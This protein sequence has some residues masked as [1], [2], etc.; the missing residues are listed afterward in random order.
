MCVYVQLIFSNGPKTIQWKKNSLFNKWC[1][2]KWISTCKIMKLDPYLTPHTKINQEWTK[3][4]NVKAK[5][6][7][8]L[9]E[10][11]GGNLCDLQL[12]NGFLEMIPKT[13]A[14]KEKIN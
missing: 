6:I 12:G 8:L 3:D 1:W 10:N 2:D 14:T 11:T 5:T 9:E 4:L 7:K 13:H